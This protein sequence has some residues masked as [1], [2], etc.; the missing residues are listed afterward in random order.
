MYNKDNFDH[1]FYRMKKSIPS[2]Y[3]LYLLIAVLKVYPLLLLTHTGGYTNPPE[4]LIK[5]HTY[6]R[7]FSITFY[8]NN[9]FSGSNILFFIGIVLALNFLL[10]I[11][12]IYYLAISKNI[13][14]IDENYG[15][16]SSLGYTF[17]IFAHFAFFKYIVLF[18]YFNEINFLPLICLNNVIDYD[19]ITKNK[20]F[21]SRNINNTVNE[22]CN[23]NQITFI[24]IS[25]M[26]F[27]IDIGFYWLLTSRFF[28]YNVLSDYNWNFYPNFIFSFEFMESFSQCFYILFLFYKN[29]TFQ[30]SLD[31][32]VIVIFIINLYQTFAKNLF[33]TANTEKFVNIAKFVRLL[34]YFAAA[35]I[36]IFTF[37]S[38]SYP[39]DINIII[40]IIIECLIA[41]VIIIISHSWDDDY[42][43]NI[44]VNPLQ[45]LNDKNIY[46]TLIFLIKEFNIFQDINHKFNDNNLDLFLNNY[47]NHLKICED[48][49]C[50]CKNYVKKVTGA[51]NTIK[52]GYT[53]VIN[54]THMKKDQQEEYILNKF[55]NV[56][57]ANINTTI[58]Y[59]NNVNLNNIKDSQRQKLIYQLRMKLITAVKKLISYKLEKL[60]NQI[61]NSLSTNFSKTTKDFIRINFYSVN[62]LCNHAYYKTQFL[63]FEFLSDFFKKNERKYHFNLIYYHYLKMFSINEYNQHM[64]QT[65]SVKKEHTGSGIHLDFRTVLSLCVKYYEIE[66]KLIQTAIDYNDFILYFTTREQIF[67]NQLLKI[68]R[69]FKSDYKG[70]TRYISHYF[71]NDKINNLFVCTK[72]ILFFKILHFD[73]PETLHNKLIIQIHDTDD[74]NKAHSYIDSNYYMIINYLNGEF[75]I[76]FISHEL[77]IVLEYSEEELKDKDFHILMPDK[78]RRLHKNMIVNEVKGK[79]STSG[80]KEI[81]FVAKKQNCVLFDIQYKF[82]LN[83]KGEIT[84]LTVVNLKKPNKDFRMCFCCIEDHGD[85]LAMNKEY[86]DYFILSMKLLEYVKIDTEKLILQNMGER[87]RNFFK[88]EENTDFQE[89]FDYELFLQSLFDEEFE[90]LKEKNELLYRRKYARWEVLKE[91]N[92]KGRYYTRYIEL[93]IKQRV[94]GRKKIYFLKYSVKITL[95]LRSIEPHSTTLSLIHAV[96]ISKREMAKLSFYKGEEIYES[97]TEKG[98]SE[99]PLNES[100][101]DLFESQSQISSAVSQLKERNSV[102][103]FRQK[104]NSFQFLPKSKNILILMISIGVISVV[105]IFYNIISLVWKKNYYN[106]LEKFL[107]VDA[108]SIVLKKNMFLLTEAMLTLSFIEDGLIDSNINYTLNECIK[109]IES[110]TDL[111]DQVTYNIS[112]INA[113]Y[114]DD[115]I[116]NA[117]VK[118]TNGLSYIFNGGYIYKKGGTIY[119]QELTR[120]KKLSL[121]MI[122]KYSYEDKINIPIRQKENSNI[123]NY[124]LLEKISSLQSNLSSLNISFSDQDIS[125]FFLINN[126]FP[127]FD[128]YI[129]SLIYSFGK[130]IK[131]FQKKTLRNIFIMKLLEFIIVCLIITI[132]WVFI[133]LGYEKSKK[134]MITLRQ[135]IEENNIEMTLQKIDEFIHFSNNFN[136][137]SLY[138]IADL[139]LKKVENNEIN[140]ITTMG[141]N[142]MGTFLSQ[143]S[144]VKKSN[145]TEVGNET[146]FS[147]I[148]EIS[149]GINNQKSTNLIF[150][151]TDN[152]RGTPGNTP[153]GNTT[154]GNEPDGKKN[155]LKVMHRLEQIKG[156]KKTKDINNNNNNNNNNINNNNIGS[157]LSLPNYEKTASKESKVSNESSQIYNNENIGENNS[158]NKNENNEDKNNKINNGNNNNDNINNRNNEPIK[159]CFSNKNKINNININKISSIS[160]ASNEKDSLTNK[161]IR[162]VLRTKEGNIKVKE[163]IK[164]KSDNN[165]ISINEKIED[166]KMNML[167]NE[168]GI[169]LTPGQKKNRVTKVQFKE[170]N[171]RYYSPGQNVN[172]TVDEN[173]KNNQNK[174]IDDSSENG[175]NLTEY[176]TSLN[177]NKMNKMKFNQDKSRMPGSMNLGMSGIGKMNNRPLLNEIKSSNNSLK[178][179]MPLQKNSNNTFPKKNIIL[180]DKNITPVGKDDKENNYNDINKFQLID[181][182]KAVTVKKT[183]I[184][185]KNNINSKEEIIEY[186]INNIIQN[187]LQVKLILNITLGIFI[188]LYIVSLS[189]NFTFNKNIENAKLYTTLLYNK[190]SLLMGN[191]LNYQF[192]VIR[193]YHDQYNNIHSVPLEEGILRY[194]DNRKALNYFETEKNPEIL[195]STYKYEMNLRDNDFCIYFSKIYSK[196]YQELTEDEEKNE[197]L[198]VGEQININGLANAE[199]YVLSTLIVLIEDWDNL[200]KSNKS[201][202]NEQVVE[203]LKFDKFYAITEEMIYTFRKYTRLLN[204][205]IMDDI[206]KIFNKIAIIET[207]LGLT[208]IILNF[209]FL[210]LGL[211]F[212]IY[213]IKSVEILISWMSH[214]I[215]QN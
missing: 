173:F 122:T 96:K 31:I 202:T 17:N 38:N 73:I 79:N 174:E 99:I 199:S 67:F 194:E 110:E 151:N 92:R 180:N 1:I 182:G 190:T 168:E 144:S 41:L 208:K 116:D 107:V 115:S 143:G 112:F 102:R 5:I 179:V 164:L 203:L 65:R 70:V 207:I 178:N 61:E 44:L 52:S 149:K 131:S 42:I 160:S 146:N 127:T 108:D 192:H 129:N 111:M 158:L 167:K 9:S 161:E 23:G 53:T 21:G 6:F 15:D 198:N 94:L 11:L 188:I 140:N 118:T 152:N 213:P 114:F 85:V 142:S 74:S 126:V 141:T 128:D 130:L 195:E 117:L 8:L 39:N 165:E 95:S 71:K 16:V 13:K 206:G 175:N 7:Y 197:C 211:L 69:K 10:I 86:E 62:I 93:N 106:Q 64:S 59:T 186:K 101:D 68:I 2:S 35:F 82:L 196:M 43:K 124:L 63:Y 45:N 145:L 113:K 34:S 19:S 25:V 28:D 212:I 100:H 155:L 84:I 36:A 56:L 33:Y 83:L 205:Y 75:V 87:I 97:K 26:N 60:T 157:I 91:M 32:F 200:Y 172:E 57:A 163:E 55:F 138:Y 77:L 24:F 22:L 156:I 78:L 162:S 147:N 120:I 191:I 119:Y 184:P 98:Q 148:R 37:C 48:M 189:V 49:H 18:Q 166:S 214:K 210:I 66:D 153:L 185:N 159:S 76:K 72:L 90:V 14:K 81:F 88:D 20:I 12:L 135:K 104:K 187:N 121:D 80:A 150:N 133:F 27:L 89:Q 204:V 30:L 137:G 136:I 181:Q 4:K 46:Q 169:G 123:Y 183:F 176:K 170:K 139:D 154:P 177:N 47:V 29:K 40:L 171:V 54:F 209:V 125:L 193:D 103:L 105:S 51:S 58:K 109:L 215:M 50:P 132:E 134:K 3:N 201:L